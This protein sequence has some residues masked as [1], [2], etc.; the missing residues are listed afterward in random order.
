MEGR[1]YVNRCGHGYHAVCLQQQSPVSRNRGNSSSSTMM[2]D[3]DSGGDVIIADDTVVSCVLCDKRLLLSTSSQPTTTSTAVTGLPSPR[4]S[5]SS[6]PDN[7]VRI[8]LCF[9]C[10]HTC[11]RL[12]I[13]ALY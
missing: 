5:V 4:P 11:Q 12:I 9:K 3:G 7:R 2:M 10:V 1:I 13:V 8:I 6:A